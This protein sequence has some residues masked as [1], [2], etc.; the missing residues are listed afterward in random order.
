MLAAQMKG[1]ASAEARLAA[2][3]EAH[4]TGIVRFRD[5]LLEF[6]T[7]GLLNHGQYEVVHE[8]LLRLGE[9]NRN[10]SNTGNLQDLFAY[11]LQETRDPIRAYAQ[12]LADSVKVVP[13]D[14]ETPLI[15]A[16]KSLDGTR[17]YRKIGDLQGYTPGDTMLVT[18]TMAA[19]GDREMSES[20]AAF[21]RAT[22]SSA[23]DGTVRQEVARMAV[24]S[25]HGPSSTFVLARMRGLTL[26]LHR[27]YVDAGFS[28]D[29]ARDAQSFYDVCA[30]FE[31]EWI[32]AF[33]V[34]TV[35]ESPTW[36]SWRSRYLDLRQK[37]PAELVYQ[38]S[39]DTLTNFFHGTL[40]SGKWT[41]ASVFFGGVTD[42]SQVPAAIAQIVNQYVAEHIALHDRPAEEL[43]DAVAE[44]LE[45]W[46]IGFE[47]GRAIALPG[48]PKKAEA[49]RS[50]FEGA[51]A[52]K[53]RSK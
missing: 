9:R 10:P 4:R 37:L 34:G 11:T 12:I 33:L 47:N 6:V 32:N 42:A 29:A 5:R 14:P 15:P 22:R 31:P 8:H 18:H 35:P 2:L 30:Q 50:Q 13:M 45:P 16:L 7:R 19:Y 43:T 51:M 1:R 52:R 21:V 39:S 17:V 36:H 25:Q 40:E 26:E 53:L 27:L 44:S 20:A 28:D 41:D 23:D 24:Q 49:I 38:L 46:G 3:S 48:G